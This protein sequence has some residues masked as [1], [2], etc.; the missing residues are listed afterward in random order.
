MAMA[1]NANR[2]AGDL[3]REARANAGVSQAQLALRA[4]VPRSTVERIEAGSRQP[5]LP[6]LYRLLAALELSIEPRLVPA[7]LSVPADAHPAP[8][9]A[10]DRVRAG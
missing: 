8:G 3:L 7:P 5:S 10:G 6:T 2:I 4:G 9:N 1:E